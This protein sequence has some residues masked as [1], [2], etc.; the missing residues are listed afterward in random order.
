MKPTEREIVAEVERLRTLGKDDLRARWS[1]L[2]GKAPPPALTKDLLGRMIAWR[3]QEKFYGGHDKATLRVLDG[4]AR[5]KVAKPATEP[6]LRPGTVL[7][8][9][10]GGVR[11]TVTVTADG[12]VWQDRTYPSLSA[13]ARAITG[14]SWNGRRFFGLRKGDRAKAGR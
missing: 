4:L 11:Y 5:G 14:T 13:V 12:F 8:R 10:H 7:M 1:T 3:I 2:F 6:R 9:E